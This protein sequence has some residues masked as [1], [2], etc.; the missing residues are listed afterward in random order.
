MAIIQDKVNPGDVISSD[1]IN[2]IIALLNQH[3]LALAGSG[4]TPEVDLIVGFEPPTQQ[5]VGRNLRIFG[6]FDFP[7]VGNSLT[8]DGVPI[9]SELF[10]A[11]S[12][13]AQLVVVV[14]NSIQVSSARAVAI[15]VSNSKGTDQ[16]NYTLLPAVSALPDPE[17]ISAL[18]VGTTS[19]ALRSSQQVRVVG[20]NFASPAGQ[21]RVRLIFNPG[22]SQTAFPAQSDGS[23]P[24]DVAASTINPAPEQSTLVFTM[25]AIGESLIANVGGTAPAVLEIVAPGANNPGT[26]PV[27]VRRMA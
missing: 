7:L 11:G 10:L 2:R 24:I 8:I 4:G 12:N 3:D 15:R 22:P 23:L 13:N 17:L 21:N 6:D 27:S 25:P 19:G 26:L 20:R 9:P 5:N 18:T 1:L 14:P 16:R